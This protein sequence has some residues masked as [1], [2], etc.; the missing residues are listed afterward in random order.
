MRTE[1]WNIAVLSEVLSVCS[2]Q[3]MPQ[4]QLYAKSAK[5]NLNFVLCSLSSMNLQN[6]NVLW[7]SEKEKK[8]KAIPIADVRDPTLYT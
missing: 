1:L 8:K 6:F 4:A 3:H 5:Q 2:F 7:Y